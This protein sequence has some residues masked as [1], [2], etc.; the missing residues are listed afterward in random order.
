MFIARNSYEVAILAY[1]GRGG[2]EKYRCGPPRSSYTRG[3]TELQPGT[4][5]LQISCV[6]Q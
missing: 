1:F 6:M 3:N 5:V 2:L 4:A